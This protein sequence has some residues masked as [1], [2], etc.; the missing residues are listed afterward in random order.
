MPKKLQVKDHNDIWHDIDKWDK[1]KDGIVVCQTKVGE[2]WVNDL[3][4]DRVREVKQ[5]YLS[6]EGDNID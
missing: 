1:R 2:F 5:E 4:K 3:N 6:G